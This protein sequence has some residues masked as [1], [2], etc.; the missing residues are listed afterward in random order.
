MHF[1]I[2]RLRHQTPNSALVYRPDEYSFA[3][4]PAPS[5]FTS[6]L[7]DDLNLELNEGGKVISV[8]GM[9]PHTR[10]LPATLTPPD[11]P[12]GDIFFIP[13]EPLSRGIS[14]QL[15]R[16]RYLPVLIDRKSGWILI[17]APGKPVSSVKF[18]SGVIFEIT[19]QGQLCAI[20]LK[21]KQELDE[22]AANSIHPH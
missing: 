14:L 20:W 4:V 2:D 11:A 3:V 16:D 22:Q 6:V 12:C 7:V 9:C 18:L 17:Q 13:D 1:R 21:P 15:N 19:E 10:W 5:G 8:W